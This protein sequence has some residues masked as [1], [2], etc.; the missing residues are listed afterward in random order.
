MANRFG[1]T[2]IRPDYYEDEYGMRHPYVHDLEHSVEWSAD[3]RSESSREKHF[4]GKG[5]RNFSRTD[6]FLREEVCEA[7]LRDSELDP[8]EIDVTVYDGIVTLE[9]SVRAREDRY[10]AEDL[11]RDVS[12]VKEVNNLLSRRKE[13]EGAGDAQV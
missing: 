4:H 3:P 7:F 1:E 6:E 9:G 12:G 8:R 11:A 10:L 2:Q 5:P 13:Y